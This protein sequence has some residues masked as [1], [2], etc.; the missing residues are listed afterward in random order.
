MEETPNVGGDVARMNPDGIDHG[1]LRQNIT[2]ERGNVIAQSGSRIEFSTNA[3]APVT[4]RQATTPGQA[5]AAPA[6]SPPRPDGRASIQYNREPG[7]DLNV[8]GI[9]PHQSNIRGASRE[10]AIAS[11]FN[12]MINNSN[13]RVPDELRLTADAIQLDANGNVTGVRVNNETL[14]LEGLA[15]RMI[16]LRNGG[17]GP[18]DPQEKDLL[19]Q[20]LTQAAQSQ[21]SVYDRRIG[22]DRSQLT[23]NYATGT[24]NATQEY[25]TEPTGGAQLMDQISENVGTML[26]T[27]GQKLDELAYKLQQIIDQFF[28]EVAMRLQ[29]QDP[30][31]NIAQKVVY[32]DTGWHGNDSDVA[33]GRPQDD[34]RQQTNQIRERTLNPNRPYSTNPNADPNYLQTDENGHS[35]TTQAVAERSDAFRRGDFSRRSLAQNEVSTWEAIRNAGR[36]NA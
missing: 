11:A 18:V 29:S 19:T 20:A 8:R 1:T 6:Q 12:T 34:V 28:G 30:N 24:S 27:I 22:A 17:N 10:A 13:G 31:A 33:M 9:N 4:D 7:V 26:L 14:S 2:D 15:E 16:T 25:D 21:N 36:T 5:P 35:P 32:G 3:T 23:D